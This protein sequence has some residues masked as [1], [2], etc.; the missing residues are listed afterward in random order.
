[1]N[2]THPNPIPSEARPTPPSNDVE[3]R[4]PEIK[5]LPSLLRTAFEEFVLF[6]LPYVNVNKFLYGGLSGR[7]GVN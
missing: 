6:K 5:E 2:D 1:M 3:G 4:L 7:R